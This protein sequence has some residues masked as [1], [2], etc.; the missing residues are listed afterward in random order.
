MSL[1]LNSG[2][3]EEVISWSPLWTT[4]YALEKTAQW[5]SKH[6][7]KEA[8]ARELCLAQIAEWSGRAPAV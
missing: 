2:L 8:G 7:T 4:Q 1:S 5:Y 6:L 3:A